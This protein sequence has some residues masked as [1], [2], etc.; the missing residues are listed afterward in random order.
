MNMSDPSVP[1]ANDDQHGSPFADLQLAD[2]VLRAIAAAG[3]EKPTPIQC[4]AIPLLLA[5]R[6]LIGQ[7]QTGTGKTGAFCWPILTQLDTAIQRP[8]VLVL[9]PTRELALQVAGAF[10]RYGQFMAK[11]RVLAVYGGQAYGAQLA[12]LARGVHVVVGTPGR[13]MDHLQRGS[14]RLDAIRHVVIDEADELL[15]MGFREDV[16]S[17]LEHAP[18]DRQTALFSA[19]M[20]DEIRAI[21][22]ATLRDPEHTAT[23]TGTRGA[24]AVRH[25]AVVVTRAQKREALAR[26]LET[27]SHDGVIVFARTRAATIDIAEDLGARGFDAAPLNGDVPQRERER[28]ID[29]LRRG[30][31]DILVATDVAAR[32]LDVER[33]SHVIN[34]DAPW[35]VEAY[36]HRIGR[37][38]RAGRGGE[39]ILFVTPAERRRLRMLENATGCRFEPMALPN[40]HAVFR[41]RSAKLLERIEDALTRPDLEPITEL[42]GEYCET[43]STPPLRVAAAL[44]HLAS[45]RR[46]L[47][48]EGPEP[49][50]PPAGGR[51][52]RTP[53]ARRRTRASEAT[54]ARPRPARQR[55]WIVPPP[56]RGMERYRIE[57]GRTHGAKPASIVATIATTARLPG[58][59]V[60]RIELYDDFSTVDLP[61]G[62]PAEVYSELRD[63]RLA[64]RKLRLSR[65]SRQQIEALADK[66]EVARG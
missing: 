62:M 61:R 14:L 19:T 30:R 43:S 33:V 29:R 37:T 46:P 48:P 16:E 59:G 36:V 60:G 10:E 54:G 15:R 26:V 51:E 25:R 5:G 50:A 13:L 39:A 47:W 45:G 4:R 22:A 7:A 12:P 3:Y 42:L 23:E 57:V 27:E 9:A 18:A 56:A 38:G 65:L 28:T 32:G 24:S 31:V 20:A 64:S 35:D 21:A 34:Y 53:P 40:R 2:P 11:L 44:A 1:A 8:Q 66:D 52:F 55:G 49:T 41:R 58:R 6:D 63:T 17:I